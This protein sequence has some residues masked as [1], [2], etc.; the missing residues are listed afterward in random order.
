MYDIIKFKKYLNENKEIIMR[1]IGK[2]KYEPSDW[3]RDVQHNDSIFYSSGLLL[4]NFLKW[5][6][7]K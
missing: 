2:E 5:C 1:Y 6:C 3:E 4:T 7:V